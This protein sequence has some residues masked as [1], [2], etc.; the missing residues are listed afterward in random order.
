MRTDPGIESIQ[1]A[2]GLVLT[3]EEKSEVGTDKRGIL[4]QRSLNRTEPTFRKHPARKKEKDNITVRSSGSGCQLRTSFAHCR[5]HAAIVDDNDLMF[6][7]P[8]RRRR[9]DIADSQG[10][11]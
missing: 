7:F 3:V 11:V 9:Q 2:A 10:S 5:E 1:P 4:Q 8:P 6:S